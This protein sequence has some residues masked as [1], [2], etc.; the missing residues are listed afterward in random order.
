MRGQFIT[1]MMFALS[2]CLLG[3]PLAGCLDF[4]GSELADLAGGGGGQLDVDSENGFADAPNGGSDTSGRVFYVS[5]DGDDDADGLSAEA[6]FKTLNRA[7]EVVRAGD[8]IAILP[9]VYAQ[10]LRLEAIGDADAPITIRGTEPGA[11][12]DG[13]NRMIVGIWCTECVNVAI[14]DLEVRNYSDVGIL[15]TLSSDVTMRRL[16]VH[17]NGNAATLEYVEGYGIMAEDS[18]R[19]TIE[20]NEVYANG[21]SPQRPGRLMGTGI[22]TF[23]NTDV[24]IRNNFSHHNIGGGILVEDSVNVLI[25]GNV[26]TGNDLDASAEK[27]WDGGLWLDGGHD[28]TVRNNTF[29][30][31][32]GPGIVI[33]NEDNQQVFGYVLENNTSTGNYYGIYIWNFGTSDFPPE[34]I[35]L[36]SGNVL[37]PNSRQDVWIEALP[38][39]PEDP[40]D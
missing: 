31:N 29:T 27:W 1:E 22:D 33:S 6:S 15:V 2:A 7:G 30:D 4:D 20:D 40:C 34:D 16:E 9:G 23:G 37:S 3:A 17:G 18:Q 10:D 32:L 13:E 35:L 28:V 24:V 11:I 8:T 26:V 36:R 5:G 14:E 25:E 38:C 12:L 21:P 39:P 19:I